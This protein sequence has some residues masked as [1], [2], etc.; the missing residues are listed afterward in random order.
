VK[1]T[2]AYSDLLALGQPVIE[3]K[4]AAVRLG[5]SSNTAS[6]ILRSTERAGLVRRVRHGL[7]ALQPKV[8]PIVLAPYLTAPYPA[9]VSSW[10]ALA[11]HGMIEQIPA[12]TEIASL[13]R[14]QNVDT[15]FGSFAIHRLATEVF[16]GYDGAPETGYIATPEKALFDTV[17]FRAPRGGTVRLPELTLPE[18]FDRGQLEEWIQHIPRPRLRTLVARGLESVLNQADIDY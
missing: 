6:Q 12:R 9:Y 4:E 17:Y 14:S 5:T 13:A 3:T 15:P 1:A 18:N 16:T 2:E 11:R 8:S 10:S 7:W